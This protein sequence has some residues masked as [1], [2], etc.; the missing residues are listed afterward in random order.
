MVTF[1]NCKINIGL[2]I[3][4]KRNDGFHDIETVFYPVQLC[5]ILEIVE[6]PANNN[7]PVFH[8]T[9]LIIDSPVEKNLCVKAY[10]LLQ[11][12]FNLPVVVMHLHKIIPFGAGLGGGSSDAAYVITSLNKIFSLG[13]SAEKMCDYAAKIG[14]D[15][16][17]FINSM[18]SVAEG[19][20]E[21]LEKIDLNLSGFQILLI[22][23]EIHISTAE[24]Y[25]GVIPEIPKSKLKDVIKLP[26]EHWKD[27]V[28][29]DFEKNLF[30]KHPRL[31][32]I[33]NKLYEIG[34]VYAAMSGSGST[35]YGLFRDKTDL[36]GLFN[37]C[38]V[39][40]GELK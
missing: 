2:N 37:D 30:I 4:R 3:L 10:R 11:A 25:S 28:F 31:A 13:L 21:I 24:A 29:N 18:P 8:N 19:R 15:C 39:W 40:E 5:D 6:R 33:K 22:K 34:A 14:S 20:G 7:L 26:I 36:K 9:G 16:A 12:D 35:I 1:P 38:F 17:F 27:F 23:P 32:Q